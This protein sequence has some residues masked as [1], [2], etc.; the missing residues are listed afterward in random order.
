VLSAF[1]KKYL[2]ILKERKKLM[3]DLRVEMKSE[4]NSHYYV[5]KLIGRY[6][7]FFRRPS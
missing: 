2:I 4:K 3:K 7:A 5:V 6:N 1:K